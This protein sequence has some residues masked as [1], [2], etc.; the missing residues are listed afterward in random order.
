MRF[1]LCCY[2]I[3]SG[4]NIFYWPTLTKMIDFFQEK[5]PDLLALQEVHNNSSKGRQFSKIKQSLGLEAGYGG[6]LSIGDGHYGNAIFSRFPIIHYQNTLLPSE[7]EQRGALSAT[8]LIDQRPIQLI[9]THLGL[10]RQ[11]R[12]LQLKQIEQLLTPDQP[13]LVVGDFNTTAP[14]S[15]PQLDDLGKRAGKEDHPTIFPLNKRIDFIFASS[16]FEL[17]DYE[18][19]KLDFSDHYPIMASLRLL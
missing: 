18:V 6:N 7:K 1:T 19:L 10:G 13:N 5:K 2:N 12:T 17:I 16:V 4:K 15:F 9:N 8:L 11:E 3:H 14:R